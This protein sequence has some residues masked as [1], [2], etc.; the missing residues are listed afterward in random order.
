MEL[1]R[2]YVLPLAALL[3]LAVITTQAA[4][5]QT[6]KTLFSFDGTDGASPYAGLVQGTNGNLYGTTEADGVND[7]GTA[8]EITPSGTLT[9]LYNFCSQSGCTDGAS[10][11]AGLVLA[12]NG[13]FYGTTYVGGAEDDGTVF[14]LTPSGTLTTLYSFCSQTSCTDGANPY[15]GL[16]LAANGNFYGTTVFGGAHGYGTV[17]EI[18]PSGKLTTLYSFCSLSGCTDGSGVTSALIQ[19]TNG[20]FYGVTCESGCFGTGGYGTVFEL[21]PKGK[22][23][24]LHTFCSVSGCADGSYPT[25]GLVQAANGNFYGTTANGGT[26]N[27]GTVFE[28]TSA[29]KLTTLY[30]F[31]SLTGCA[32]G[33]HPNAALTQAPNS[34]FY[35]TTCGSFCNAPGSGTAFEITP[36]GALTTLYNF[37]SQTGC[38]DGANPTATPLQDTNG[39][40]FGTTYYGGAD[41]AG[42]VFS[43]SDGLGSFVSFVVGSGEVGQTVEILGQGFET[44]S[45]VS[46]NG[47]SSTFK[48]VSNTYL[49]ATVPS[50]A[51]TGPVTVTETSGTLKSSKTFDVTPQIKSFSPPSG[52]VGTPVQINGVSLTQTTN[53]TIGGVK[54]T[55]TVNSDLQVTATVPANATK[56]QIVIT[57]LGGSATSSGSFAVTPFIKSF[58]PTSGPVGTSVT[59][60]GTTFNGATKVTFNGTSAAFD[61][62]TNSQVV[63]TVPS[64]ATTGPI[65][66]TT[67]EGTGTSSTNFTV[68]Q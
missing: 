68:T 5:A 65:A 10:P 53:V 60:T 31:C 67:P 47:T 13:N 24:T 7:R 11:Y 48:A 45:S 42:T 54:A 64:G 30:D 22:L 59:I 3:V 55:F 38:T 21:T 32:D 51:T 46:F 35:G 9:T 33:A 61:L 66:I 63:A 18:T 14:E 4:Q 28:I 2:N 15:A 37:C 20:N 50:G 6:F 40:F 25:A 27:W 62:E 41:N 39:T 16:V 49:T 29:G 56:G 12:T 44:T 17:Y 52:P 58:T 23:T 36:K 26:S 43:L 34:N 1:T 8:Y 19:A 57:T